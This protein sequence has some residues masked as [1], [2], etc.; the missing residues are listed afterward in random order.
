MTRAWTYLYSFGMLVDVV[1]H[2][3]EQLFAFLVTIGD[4]ILLSNHPLTIEL[5]GTGHR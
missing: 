5:V 4:C 3:T 1:L 2:F